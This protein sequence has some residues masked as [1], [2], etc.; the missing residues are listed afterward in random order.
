MFSISYVLLA[1]V[2]ALEGRAII[3][4]IAQVRAVQ[5]HDAI[6]RRPNVASQSVN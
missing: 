5:R 2:V 6:V 3:S 1:V 4:I